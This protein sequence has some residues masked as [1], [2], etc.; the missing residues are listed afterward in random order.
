[1]R[2]WLGARM[3]PSF[4]GPRLMKLS[5]WSRI[6]IAI[7]VAW[8]FALAGFV[9]YEHQSSN[10]FCQFDGDGPVC[11]H[12]FWLWSHISP[13]RFEFMLRLRRVLATATAPIAVLWFCFGLVVWIRAGFKR[14]S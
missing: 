4:V 9:G 14:M 10:M 3:P 8:L 2:G 6:T 1:M 12:I 5:G 11:Q 7:T 13:Q